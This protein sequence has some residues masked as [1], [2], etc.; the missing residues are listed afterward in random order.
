M[1]KRTLIVCPTYLHG[2]SYQENVWAEQL[3]RMGCDVRVLY[4]SE[5]NSSPRLVS[6]YGAVYEVQGVATAT[7]RNSYRPLDIR[8]PSGTF[9]PTLILAMGD[10]AFTAPLCT[11]TSLGSVPMVSMFSENLG[12]HEFDWRKRDI[13]LKQRLRAVGYLV[14]RGPGLRA[15]GRRSGVLVANT[16]QTA[17]IVLRAFSRRSERMRVA[18][19]FCEVPLGYSSEHFWFDPVM[20]ARIRQ[21]LGV[22]TEEIVICVTSAFTKTK[23]P[24]L[25]ALLEAIEAVMDAVPHVRALIIG[26]DD[27]AANATSNRDL[28]GAVATSRHSARLLTHQFAQRDRLNQL[29]NAS[30]VAAFARASISCQE[31]L[32][33]GLIGCFPDDGSL[34]HLITLPEQGVLFRTHHHGD[35]VAQLLRAIDQLDSADDREAHRRRMADASRWLGYDRIVDSILSR[36]SVPQR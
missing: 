32:G 2:R 7:R 13:G 22:R 23:L 33:T 5:S 36:V 30:D 26:F 15:V 20:R 27:T 35:L 14:K 18:E 28:R 21:E 12:M 1:T 4:A 19:K 29:L 24:Y 8:H 16:P 34:D 11:D 25:R 10:K 31:A 3:A 17:T 9:K 6:S